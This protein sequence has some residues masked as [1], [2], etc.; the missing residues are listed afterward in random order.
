MTLLH[1][2]KANTFALRSTF[3]TLSRKPMFKGNKKGAN[4][5][6]V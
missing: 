6:G 3:V 5:F 4:P 2:G 1:L